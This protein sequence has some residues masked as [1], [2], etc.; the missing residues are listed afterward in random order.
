MGQHSR[1]FG[2]LDHLGIITLSASFSQSAPARGT[3][4]LSCAGAADTV[5]GMPRS[6]RGNP[7]R[8][9]DKQG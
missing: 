6:F 1:G 2:R 7:K 3:L 4:P 9:N 5:Q 8:L